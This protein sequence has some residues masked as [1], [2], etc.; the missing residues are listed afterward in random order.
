MRSYFESSFRLAFLSLLWGILLLAWNLPLGAQ[1]PRGLPS[2]LQAFITEAV[3]ANPEIKEKS[4]LKTAS[5]EAVRPAGA[6]DDPTLSFNL[7]AIPVDNWSFRDWDMTQKQFAVTQ[8]FPFPGKRRLRS[9]VAQEQSRSDDFSLQDK[10]N[11]IR[12]RVIQGYWNLSLA[13]ASYDTTQKNKQLWEQVVQV[14]ETRYAVGRGLQAD[15]L[16]AQVELGNYLDRLLQWRQRQESQRADLNALRAQPPGAPITQP[17][18]LKSRPLTLKL[19]DLLAQAASQPRLQALKAQI[20][21]QVK[22]VDLARKDFYPDF[23]V[24]LAYGLR[25]DKFP[26]ER[27]DFFSSSFTMTVPLWQGAK[28]KPR[29]REQQARQAAA[30]DAHQSAWDRLRSA[31]KDRF[32]IL[33]RLAQQ[34][35]LYGQGIIPQARQAAD[36]SLA[37]YQTGA[38]DFAS[39]TQNLIALYNAELRWQGYLKDFESNWAEMEWLV[40]QELPRIGVSR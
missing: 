20:T 36:A 13:Y 31:I 38:L 11:E 9:E 17:Q 30:Q 7:L 29:V 10:V 1:A 39:L 40:G 24:G 18:P 37:A 12:T 14:A 26:K 4:Q 27:P 16:Q 2:D 28:L 5:Q 35:T 32:E 33:Q 22:A 8:K 6:L 3:Q 25:E 23:N 15:V 34:I 19:E 21:K